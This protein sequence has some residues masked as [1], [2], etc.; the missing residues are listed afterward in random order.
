VLRKNATNLFLKPSYDGAFELSV[1][2]CAVADVV[3]ECAI[4]RI[5]RM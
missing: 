5:T 2:F 1:V 3:G 4:S